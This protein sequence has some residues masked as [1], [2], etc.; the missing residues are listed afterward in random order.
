MS[1]IIKH[2]RSSTSGNQPDQSQIEIGELAIN[3]ADRTIYTKNTSNVVTSLG[4][5]IWRSASA[6]DSAR[7]GD[8]WY[9]TTDG[10]YSFWDGAGPSWKTLD[11]SIETAIGS[12]SSITD[13]LDSDHG[14][15]NTYFDQIN[16]RLDSEHGYAL[17]AQARDDSEHGW[18]N[19]YFDQINSRLDSEHG[20]AATTGIDIRRNSSSPSDAVEGDIWYDTTDGKYNLWAGAGPSWKSLDSTIDSAISASSGGGGSTSGEWEVISDVS[21]NVVTTFEID[22]GSSDFEYIRVRCLFEQLSGET[23]LLC[24]MRSGG[25]TI[26]GEVYSTTLDA[27]TWADTTRGASLGYGLDERHFRVG[28]GPGGTKYLKHNLNAEIEFANLRATGKARSGFIRGISNRN[29]GNDILN[30][31]GGFTIASSNQQ[32]FDGIWIFAEQSDNCK[33]T[34]RVIVE[35][36]RY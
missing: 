34:G 20:Y 28:F 35:G 16:S 31:L 29:N 8:I 5:D 32:N 21:G 1:K 30:I 9:N 22:F 12:S 25:A 26:N 33:L 14:W 2:K 10:S 11:S 17:T 6:P 4:Q 13:R 18:A 19:T 23:N 3:F 15:A 36:I 7:E 27:F 24:R